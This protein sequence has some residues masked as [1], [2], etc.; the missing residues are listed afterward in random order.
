MTRRLLTIH[1]RAIDDERRRLGREVRFNQA[2]LRTHTDPIGNTT[3]S[4]TH[5]RKPAEPPTH[6]KPADSPTNGVWRDA[7]ARAPIRRGR[8]G[9]RRVTSAGGRSRTTRVRR[10]RKPTSRESGQQRST[11]MA[12]AML[13]E[14]VEHALKS[15]SLRSSSGRRW[16]RRA[17]LGE[18][19]RILRM[20]VWRCRHGRH[21]LDDWTSAERTEL[22]RVSEPI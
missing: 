21:W 22:R 16:C 6:W 2:E 20:G 15:I 5:R 1:Q 14:T 17:A 4:A 3:H 13:R 19:G 12:M 9:A 8:R 10:R 7:C 18:R 11:T